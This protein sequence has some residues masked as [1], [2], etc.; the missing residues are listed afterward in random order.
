MFYV[1]RTVKQKKA[2]GFLSQRLAQCGF[3]DLHF[4]LACHAHLDSVVPGGEQVF[5]LG[6]QRPAGV[7]EILKG[8][9][10]EA[11]HWV[12]VRLS[13]PRQYFV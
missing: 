2:C 11:E 1:R 8:A 4:V 10:K 3:F 6:C 9:P 12:V 13:A 7:A 5:P